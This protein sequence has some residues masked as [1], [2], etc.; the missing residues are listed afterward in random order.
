MASTDTPRTPRTPQPPPPMPAGSG[1]K[2]VSVTNTS[3]EDAPQPPQTP[4]TPYPQTPQPPQG[5]DLSATAAPP[6]AGAP[7][8]LTGASVADLI[9]PETMF[10]VQLGISTI[11]IDGETIIHDHL[12][13]ANYRLNSSGSF[14]WSCL[15]SQISFDDLLAS[16]RTAH[17][18]V[19]E[20][21]D[22]MVAEFL[23]DLISRGVL[24]ASPLAQLI[25]KR[26]GSPSGSTGQRPQP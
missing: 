12:R 9:K 5:T 24:T 15:S 4:Q 6:A 1:N 13:N 23:G 20:A 19:P 10:Q 22:R 21:T 25:G 16:I 26:S 14:I 11:Q 18:A 8:T 2:T 7:V 17:D 3:G